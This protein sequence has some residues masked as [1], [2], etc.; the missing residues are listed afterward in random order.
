MRKR[1]RN[2]LNMCVLEVYFGSLGWG[3]QGWEMIST[4][5]WSRALY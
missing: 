4:Q 5:L 3:V 1:R 2:D